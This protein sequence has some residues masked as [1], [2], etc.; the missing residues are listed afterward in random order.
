MNF[1]TCGKPIFIDKKQNFSCRLT[2]ILSYIYNRQKKPADTQCCRITMCENC[3][4][5]MRM[6]CQNYHLY[7]TVQWK[8]DVIIYFKNKTNLEFVFDDLIRFSSYDVEMELRLYYSQ[9]YFA[10]EMDIGHNMFYNFL[11]NKSLLTY[12]SISSKTN[13]WNSLLYA[14]FCK[15]VAFISKTYVIEKYNLIVK[16]PISIKNLTSWEKAQN[17]LKGEYWDEV[18]IIYLI[19]KY[20]LICTKSIIKLN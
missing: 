15:R 8:N 16:M 20:N 10:G 5:K 7:N 13:Y 3:R 1:G 18:D 2:K 17:F 19:N 9:V 11:K 4:M 14:I 12:S 6:H